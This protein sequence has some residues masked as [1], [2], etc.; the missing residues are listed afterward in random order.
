MPALVIAALVTAALV[1]ATDVATVVL[2]ATLMRF[3]VVRLPLAALGLRLEA[4]LVRLTLL[5]RVAQWLGPLLAWRGALLGERGA[6][7]DGGRLSFLNL[8]AFG[9]LG[10]VIG[11][12]IRSERGAT[13]ALVEAGSAIAPAASASAATATAAAFALASRRLVKASN[14]SGIQH[15]RLGVGRSARSV[16]DRRRFDICNQIWG[17]EL[18]LRSRGYRHDRRH[19]DGRVPTPGECCIVLRCGIGDGRGG[20]RRGGKL[21][22]GTGQH[23]FEGFDQIVLPQ[24]AAILYVMF[25]RQMAQILDRKGGEILL[26]RHR[27]T[28]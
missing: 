17:Y 25:T 2:T 15:F 16:G 23:R 13:G 27:K 3:A 14:G 21:R 5:T 28:S 19:C 20:I 11:Q 24:P 18:G 6:I 9:T 1:A 8:I 10:A 26:V 4:V 12:A 7:G 22:T